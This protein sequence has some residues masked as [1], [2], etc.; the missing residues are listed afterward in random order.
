MKIKLTR[1]QH[2]QLFKYR[3]HGLITYYEIIDD[4]QKKDIEMYKYIMLPARIAGIALSPIAILFGGIPLMINLIK[5]C[6]TKKQ[7]GADVISREWFYKELG[8]VKRGES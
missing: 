8:Q 5:E 3:K 1:K 7:I 2:N 6:A 4:P